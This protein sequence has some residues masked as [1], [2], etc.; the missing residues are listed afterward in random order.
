M[1]G[2]WFASQWRTGAGGVS[3]VGPLGKS[4]AIWGDILALW[5]DEGTQHSEMWVQ[6]SV[7]SN[8]FF[9]TGRKMPRNRCFQDANER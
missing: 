3:L 8:Y 5:H 6:N 4:L 9:A 2:L 7:L 1:L